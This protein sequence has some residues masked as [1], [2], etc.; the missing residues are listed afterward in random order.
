MAEWGCARPGMG[1]GWQEPT[2]IPQPKVLRDALQGEDSEFALSILALSMKPIEHRDALLGMAWAFMRLHEALATSTSTQ[3]PT[4][5]TK[6]V[7]K[8]K[9][10]R[11]LSG[12]NK[13]RREM[14]ATF[15]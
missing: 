12:L 15:S 6:A 3:L 1:C 5:E 14:E 8:D 7:L 2:R 4:V 13:V 9:A 10:H 11:E